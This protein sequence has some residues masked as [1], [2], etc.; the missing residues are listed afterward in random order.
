MTRNE[1]IKR[2]QKQFETK[3]YKSAKCG[4]IVDYAD[5]RLELPA[6]KNLFGDMV[7]N[8]SATYHNGYSELN[9]KRVTTTVIIK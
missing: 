5:L 2:A 3:I 8:V 9:N 6:Y 7:I 4:E 1:I